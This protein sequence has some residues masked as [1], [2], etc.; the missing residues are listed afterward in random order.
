MQVTV[1][2]LKSVMQKKGYKWYTDRPNLIGI[3]TA[4]DEPDVFNDFFCVVEGETLQIFPNTTNPGIYWLK[5]PMNPNGCAILKPGQWVNCWSLGFHCGK[6]NHKALTQTGTVKVYRDNT[7]DDRQTYN[8]SSVDTGLFG[9]NI[10]GANKSGTTTKIHK[11]SAGCQVFAKWEDK[12]AVM[13]ICEKYRGTTGNKFTYTLLDE[14]DLGG[15]RPESTG[16]PIGGSGDGGGGG[17]STGT[18]GYSAPQTVRE[19][20]IKRLSE[21]EIAEQVALRRKEFID[22][23]KKNPKIVYGKK[24][25]FNVAGEFSIS[26]NDYVTPPGTIISNQEI[27]TFSITTLNFDENPYDY[28]SN[29]DDFVVFGEGDEYTESGFGGLDEELETIDIDVFLDP[30]KRLGI[31]TE[32]QYP[33]PP[34]D[35]NSPPPPPGPNNGS[36]GPKGWKGGSGDAKSWA[37]NGFVVQGSKV[38]A[39]LS[40]PAKY[41][42]NPSLNKTIKSEYI[43][44][45][46]G[47]TQF[48]YGVRLLAIIMAQKEGFSPGTRSYRTNNPGNIGNT[49]SGSNK[50]LATLADGIKLQCNYISDVANGKHK[51]Y[52]PLN[53]EYYMPPYY[54]PEIAKNNGPG[55]PYKGMSAYL[56]GYRFVY[57]GSI[58][59][60]VK[61]YATGARQGNDYISMI[62]SW[63]R[64]NGYSWV[65]EETTIKQIL[66]SN[67]KPSSGII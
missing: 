1:T 65:S 17:S 54:S 15:A 16:A 5:N 23:Q 41:N 56:P 35:P 9:I 37:K 33:T 14:F 22:K 36:S 43:P 66:D 51:I 8:E 13:A 40:G 49:D 59:Q 18:T 61:I 42:L 20:E 21:A 48:S 44:V 10:H 45:I 50:S 60:Y 11:W 52:G 12:E 47:L 34:G 63:F 30:S 29:V 7:R 6:S 58:E 25:I 38:P 24:Y 4:K 19:I 3:R 67:Q 46:K 53:K 39:E 62:V 2:L 27:G 32:T 26:L 28:D 55:G 31:G 57:T 64:Q